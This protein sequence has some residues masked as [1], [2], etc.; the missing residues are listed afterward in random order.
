M[1][2]RVEVCPAADLGPGERR[3]VEAG[4]LSIGVF[5]V[6]GEYHALLNSCRH[7]HGPVCE[8]ALMPGIIGEYREPGKRVEETLSEEAHVVR[9]PWHGWTYDVVTGEHTGDADIS[10]PTFDV[11]SEDGVLYVEV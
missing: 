11:V 4:P 6:G 5:N 7:Q 1:S 10:L 3:I 9:C 2:E 8:G